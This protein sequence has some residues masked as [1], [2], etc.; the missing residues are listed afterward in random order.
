MKKISQH[1]AT[2]ALQEVPGAL[3]KL[4]A[5]R[6]FWKDQA[7]QRMHSDEVHKVAQMM[8]DKGLDQGMSHEQLEESLIKSASAGK[9]ATIAMAVEMV[10]PDMGAKLASMGDRPGNGGDALSRFEQFLLA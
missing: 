4:A 1:H 2:L 9:L 8:I 10:G 3:R 7:Q 6:D 5:E